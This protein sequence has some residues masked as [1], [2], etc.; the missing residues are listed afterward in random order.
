MGTIGGV[1]V[2]AVVLGVLFDLNPA[3]IALA[4]VIAVGTVWL[5]HTGG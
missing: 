5:I 2:A 1:I 4:I 3:G